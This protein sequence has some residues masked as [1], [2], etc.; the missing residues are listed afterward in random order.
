MNDTRQVFP[1]LE[2]KL[3]V[4]AADP[5]FLAVSVQISQLQLSACRTMR[6]GHYIRKMVA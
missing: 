2:L 1:F 6:A 5:G 4:P 3:F